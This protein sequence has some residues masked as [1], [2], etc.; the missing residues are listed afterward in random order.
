M[1]ELAKQ[2]V[3]ALG[4]EAPLFLLL[5]LQLG[6]ALLLPPFPFL[7]RQEGQSY[8]LRLIAIVRV[9]RKLGDDGAMKRHVEREVSVADS[10]QDLT[11]VIPQLPYPDMMTV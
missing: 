1:R 3:A 6:F 11:E 4:G 7:L 2:R 5:S 8:E 9:G 10:L